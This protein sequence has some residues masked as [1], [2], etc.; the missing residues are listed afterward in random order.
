MSRKTEAIVLREYNTAVALEPIILGE[1]RPD[2]ALVQIH[3]T[4][5]CHTD[6]LCMK[7][8]LP[9]PAPVV[10]G[11]EGL[12]GSPVNGL[13]CFPINT[14]LACRRRCRHRQRNRYHGC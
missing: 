3:A 8:K 6:L 4:G 7:G 13:Y 12:C 5:I 14:E 1:L 9:A 11:H 10:L 2:E